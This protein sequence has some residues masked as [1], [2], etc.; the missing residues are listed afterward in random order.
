M[1]HHA[2]SFRAFLVGIAGLGPF[3]LNVFSPCLP[4][5][6]AEFG[7]DLATV[8][9]SA[10]LSILA[11]AIATVL[12]GPLTDLWGRRPVLAVSLGIYVVAGITAALAPHISLLVAGR[13]LQ[14]ASSSVAFVTAR[15]LI[16]DVYGAEASPRA[17]ARISLATVAGVVIA[18]LAG[19][20]MIREVGWRA[21]FWSTAAVGAL[22]WVAAM[23]VEETSSR[24]V[25][26]SWRAGLN[27]VA[28]I[29]RAPAFHGFAMQ[30]ALHF[31]V[32]FAFTMTAS[33][34][35]VDV[36]HQEPTSYGVWF[37][38]LSVAVGSGLG[39]ADRLSRHTAPATLAATGSAIAMLGAGISAWFL[40]DDDLTPARLFVPVAIS[41][42]GIGLAVPGTNAGVMAVRPALAGTASGLMGFQQY[43]LAG[44]FAQ[45]VAR[46]A[47]S[48]TTSLAV[49]SLVGCGGALA[50]GFLSLAAT[51]TPAVEVAR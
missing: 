16:H 29:L 1:N 5:V 37:V 23:R 39:A 30:S 25:A 2:W 14:A 38:L 22:L 10:S 47:S 46:D 21:V 13:L 45:L 31:A 35:M 43:L 36:L 18:P 26:P 32:F 24:R 15:A 49:A 19:G 4:W 48:T 51:R 34:V 28:D 9:L 11:A 44:V 7:V 27:G 3:S 20:L 8:Q 12:A 42:L 41:A 40:L 50:F 17:I 33:H 6:R